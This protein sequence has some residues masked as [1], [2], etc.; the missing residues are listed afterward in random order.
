MPSSQD[1]AVVRELAAQAAEIAALPAQEEKRR[2]WRCLNGLRPERP[3]VMIDQVC[4]NEMDIGDQ[5]TL[6]CEDPEC[7]GYEG[8][9]RRTLFQWR[10]F[11]VDMVV[12]PF[13]RV[14]K[15]VGNT[16]FGVGAREDIAVTDP[17]NSVVGHR[18]INQFRTD[19]DLERIRAPQLTH[20]A[21]ETERRL[22]VA[23]E[24]LGGLLEPR[25][26]GLDPYLSLWDPIATWM[27]VEGALWGL[28]DRPEYMHALVGR[29]ADGYAAML[30][31]AE[32]QG[33][34]CAPQSTIHC[35]GGYTDELPAEGFDPQRPRTKDVWGCGLAQMFST[36]SPAHFREFE[37]EY[38]SP[39][40]ER[41]GLV[42]YGCCDPLDRKMA[43]VRM[44]PNVRKVSM[45]AWVDEERG[46]SELDGEYVYS[47]KPSPAVLATDR[48]DAEHARADLVATRE[49]CR[50]HG[51]PLEIILKDISTVRYDPQRLSEWATI[52][53]QVVEE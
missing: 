24:L 48:F 16:G 31:Q 13:V 18:F 30:D 15:A 1:R 23:D 4:W 39:L 32:E 44:I 42:Y 11:P 43:E 17:T 38:V 27:S 6:R 7:R 26:E 52:A 25:A 19:E 50:R 3:M 40:F 51:C 10:H 46:A 34:L 45:S 28:A 41:F 20:D 53:M 2:L 22:A 47:R 49:V 36:V 29:V 37:V 5:L 21:V 12:E 14:P 33:L 8:L 35:T 9:L